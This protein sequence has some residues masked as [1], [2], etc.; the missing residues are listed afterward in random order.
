MNLTKGYTENLQHAFEPIQPNS[1]FS[2]GRLA[3]GKYNLIT[4]Q[5]GPWTPFR[6][7]FTTRPST[8]TLIHLWY[9]SNFSYDF[10]KVTRSV[11]WRLG[12]EINFAFVRLFVGQTRAI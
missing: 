1:V 4:G 7:I 2:I 11:I 9:C 6:L 10:Q 8:W 12:R 5:K 3:S